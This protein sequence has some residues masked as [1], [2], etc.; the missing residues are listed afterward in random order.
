[1]KTSYEFNVLAICP[2]DGAMITYAITVLLNHRTI[3]VEELIGIVQ[4]LIDEPVL[5]EDLTTRLYC[6]I[7]DRFGPTKDGRLDGRITT[8]GVHSGVKITCTA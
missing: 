3:M 4:G 2:V 8:V 5:Q 7:R 1:M 6:K